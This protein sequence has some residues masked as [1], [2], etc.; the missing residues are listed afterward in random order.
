MNNIKIITYGGKTRVVE[1]REWEDGKLKE[2]S[3]NFF[4]I[5]KETQD[6][7]YFGED[8]DIYKAD[9]VNSHK[10]AWQ[11][12]KNK[13]KHGLMMP[14]N[15]V[16][17]MK[18]YQEIA[19]EVAMD[20]AEIISLNEILKT[21]A[22]IFSKCLKTQEGSVLNADEKGFK[23]YAHGIGIIQDEDLLLAEYGFINK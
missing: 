21:L 17:G 16:I 9:K 19:P 6:V 7:F 5:C 3:R 20:R 11:A 2:V 8:V 22:G 13:A 10:G 14:G 15:T 18:Y 1:E 12:G 23:T 4:A